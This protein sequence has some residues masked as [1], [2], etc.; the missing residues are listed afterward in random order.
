MFHIQ[1]VLQ[2]EAVYGEEEYCVRTRLERYG[3]VKR[4][5]NGHPGRFMNDEAPIIL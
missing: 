4:T 2:T 5:A 3:K 1:V